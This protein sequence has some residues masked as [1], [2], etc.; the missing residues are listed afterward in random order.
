MAT[1]GGLVEKFKPKRSQRELKNNG[2]VYDT[3]IF[4]KTRK[5]IYEQKMYGCIQSHYYIRL[6]YIRTSYETS[7]HPFL[8]RGFYSVLDFSPK[9]FVGAPQKVS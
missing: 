2:N 3:Y 7:V 5:K 1:R 4:M 6:L 8:V 9:R